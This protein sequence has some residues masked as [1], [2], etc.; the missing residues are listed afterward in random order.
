ML[1]LSAGLQA[2]GV[3]V[4]MEV[5]RER[6]RVRTCEKIVDSMGDGL[7]CDTVK[8]RAER[9]LEDDCGRKM[10]ALTQI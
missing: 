1:M 9:D 5:A 4:R 6:K 7:F 10:P 3:A 8:E 2:A